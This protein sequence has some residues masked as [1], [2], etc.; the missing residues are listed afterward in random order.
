MSQFCDSKT[1]STVF[2]WIPALL[3]YRPGPAYGVCCRS[4]KIRCSPADSSLQWI[5]NDS[6][7]IL[8]T[9]WTD[10]SPLA[11]APLPSVQPDWGLASRP[12]TP[13]NDANEEDKWRE[14]IL[15]PLLKTHCQRQIIGP[16]ILHSG[17]GNNLLLRVR[18]LALCR[19]CCPS[20]GTLLIRR[21]L[22]RSK[23]AWVH[24]LPESKIAAEFQPWLAIC[25]VP[26]SLLF[27]SLEIFTP[28]IRF[29]VVGGSHSSKKETGQADDCSLFRSFSSSI[30]DPA[31][32]VSQHE[33][34]VTEGGI[35]VA[36]P[37]MSNWPR[38]FCSPA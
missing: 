7:S 12:S 36:G 6:H 15:V 1:S 11:V 37:L 9:L 14:L 16:D 24:A 31:P 22:T 23:E 25:P 18:T 8:D 32:R 13:P 27:V 35:E 4:I 2:L 21:C 28:S 33:V 34:A 30:A 38:L 20:S 17:Q 3:L 10:A 19:N 5:L 26:T 29:S